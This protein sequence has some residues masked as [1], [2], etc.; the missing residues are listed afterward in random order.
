METAIKELLTLTAITEAFRIEVY[1]MLKKYNENQIYKFDYGNPFKFVLSYIV[2]FLANASIAFIALIP[3]LY[4]VERLKDSAVNN[5]I[6]NVLTAIFV[7]LYLVL[8]A[9]LAV[10]IVLPKRAALTDYCVL[11]KRNTI[12]PFR[13]LNDCILYSSIVECSIYND[14]VYYGKLL[15]VAFFNKNSLVEIKDKY[16]KRYYVPVKNAK[17]FVEAVNKKLY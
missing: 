17:D 11:I 9:F 6:K 16:N 2:E 1:Y 12:D 4:I 3:D 13:G 14:N 8:I 15:P 7:V 10:I 5:S